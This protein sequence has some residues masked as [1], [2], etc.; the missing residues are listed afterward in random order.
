MT[1]KLMAMVTDNAYPIRH[2]FTVIHGQ[3]MHDLDR[4]EVVMLPL[5][6]RNQY[7]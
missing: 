3:N 7:L 2:Q 5:D 6:R 4:E 1:S